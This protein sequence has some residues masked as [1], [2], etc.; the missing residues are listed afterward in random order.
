[1]D[2]EHQDAALTPRF[3]TSEDFL[4]VCRLLNEAGARYIVMGRSREHGDEAK[5]NSQW[6]RRG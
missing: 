5:E 1:M 2:A 3:P 4:K 6:K